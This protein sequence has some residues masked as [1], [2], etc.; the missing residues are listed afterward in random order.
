MTATVRRFR[1]RRAARAVLL[2]ALAAGTAGAA[3]P[4][5][6][7]AADRLLAGQELALYQTLRSSSGRSVLA[8]NDWMPNIALYRTDC[9]AP[10]WAQYKKDDAGA[11]I[12]AVM[13]G[14]GN[15]VLYHLGWMPLWASGT[16]GHPGSYVVLQNDGNL[17]V[18]SPS[19]R[20]LWA[21]GTQENWSTGC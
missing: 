4:A 17:V 2:L 3:V 11:D 5:S 20:A 14:D 19:G 16:Y 7:A 13:Q 6:A 8:V 10:R 21:T 12:R 18:Y 15:F 9:A 1:H